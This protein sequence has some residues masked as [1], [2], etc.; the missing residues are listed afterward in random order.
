MAKKTITSSPLS[1]LSGNAKDQRVPVLPGLQ[2]I[3]Y[4]LRFSQADMAK[5]IGTSEEF[6]RRLESGAQDC[7]VGR[8]KQIATKLQA[9]GL[10]VKMTDLTDTPTPGR[11]ATLRAAYLRKQ[12]AEADAKAERAGGGA[13]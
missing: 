12:A 10:P 6:L 4:E 2:E 8:V 3:R 13:A 1:P 5:M 11:L 7:L 9:E